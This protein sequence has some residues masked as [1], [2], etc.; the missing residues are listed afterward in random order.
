LNATFLRL[1]RFPFT[2]QFELG[3]Q[4]LDMISA[5][6]L[7]AAR[8]LLGWS[9]ESL[10]EQAHIPLAGLL[11]YETGARPM[12]HNAA[13]TLKRALEKSGIIFAEDESGVRLEPAAEIV[14]L[15]KLNSS[16]DE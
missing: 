9:Q 14:P 3:G 15:E 8:G 12:P 10:A 2:G 4:K 7:R 11:D 13:A 1:A 16:N 5:S 6:Q